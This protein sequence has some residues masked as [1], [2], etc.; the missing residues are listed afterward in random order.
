MD[1]ANGEWKAL[2]AIGCFLDGDHRVPLWNGCHDSQPYT[3]E[4]IDR[5]AAR[6]KQL[7]THIETL[8]AIAAGDS[9]VTTE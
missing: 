8:E 4:Q 2:T 1:L 7:A 9:D 3:R 6:L 5:I